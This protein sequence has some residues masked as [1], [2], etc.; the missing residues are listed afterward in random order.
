M[1]T[2]HKTMKIKDIIEMD[3]EKALQVDPEYQRAA[4]WTVKQDRLLIDSLF[5]G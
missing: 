5:R 3:Q 4:E 2:E 1:K